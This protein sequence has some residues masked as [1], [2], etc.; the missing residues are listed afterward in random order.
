MRTLFTVSLWAVA[1]ISRAD[2]PRMT[3]LVGSGAKGYSGDGAA[4]LTAVL[5]SPFD[6]ALDRAGDLYFSDTMNHC[7]RVVH[8]RTGT[9][10]TV[11]GCG[12]KGYSG[13]GGPATAATMNE[14][15]GVVLD[16]HDNLYIVDRLNYAVRRV[17][18]RT[19]DIET[20]AGTGQSGYSGDSGPAVRAQLREPNGIALDGKGKL[21][22]ADV[23]DQRIRVV[24]LSSGLIQTLCG[25]GK[26]EQAGD[27]GPYRA[28]SLLGPRAVAVAPDGAI[29]VCEREGNSIRKI[30]LGSGQ[31]A[32]VAGTGKKGYSGDGG[33]ALQATF[34]G[35]KEL[36]VDARGNIYV[37][38]TENHAIR[39]IDAQTGIVTT[40]AGTGSRG[41]TGD[42]GAATAATLDRPHG[43]VVG[44]DGRIHIGDT[45][46]H[47][48]R[49]V[50]PWDAVCR[51]RLPE[52]AAGRRDSGGRMCRELPQGA[53]GGV[54]AGWCVPPVCCQ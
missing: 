26:K 7:I 40:V 18:A 2:G 36:D 15:Y 10:R 17:D 32:R 54:I 21:Y 30:D 42:G 19:G 25:T 5:N 28:A 20:I 23:A 38:D 8:G 27:G 39:R 41:G 46:N 6:V 31:I 37:V 33:P 1:L 11:A 35:P 12:R 14:P 3:T 50:V 16:Q 43:V 44:N 9:I 52:G 49:T 48:I 13:D 4:A 53:G 34:N 45:L 22:I 47:R 29:L 24:D 51:N